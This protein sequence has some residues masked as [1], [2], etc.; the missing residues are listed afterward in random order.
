[1]SN[2]AAVI[3]G[4]GQ[5][6]AYAAMSLREA[7][8]AG[9]IIVLGDEHHLPY[10]RPPLSKAMLTQETMPAPVRF[11]DPAKVAERGIELRLGTRVEGIDRAAGRVHVAGGGTVPYDRLLLATG[12]AARRLTVP[13]AERVLTMRTLE[14][15]AAIRGR[16]TQGVRVVCVGAGVIGLE[17]AASAHARGAVVTVLEAGP[18][19]MGRSL[20]PD[21]AAWIKG[22]HEAAGVRLRFGVAVRAITGAGVE[23]D[24]GVVPADLVIAGIGITRNTALAEAAGL[25]VENGIVVDE[26]GRTDDPAIFAAGDVAAFWHPFYGRRLRLEAWRHAMNHGIAV[27]KAMAGAGQAYDDIPWF[28]TD[29]HGVNLQMAGMVELAAS[30]VMRGTLGAASFA[31]FHLDGAGCV[32]AATGVNAAREVRAAQALIPLRRPVDAAELA[33]P[34]GNL[35]NL[36]AAARRGSYAA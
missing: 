33:D 24:D 4:G 29:Q 10:D 20:T 32:V 26:F 21:F 36:V 30:T 34:A 5:S 27:G 11:H 35:Q 31:A 12:A 19:C 6:G 7:G 14:D 2:A 9:R 15:A 1:M 25:A 13:G 3:V 18:V 16:L 17:V 28:W 22:L 8:F 23:C